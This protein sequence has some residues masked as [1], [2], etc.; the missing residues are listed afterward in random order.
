MRKN[1]VVIGLA[2]PV[3]DARGAR[4]RW[5][6]WRPTVSIGQ[7]QDLLVDRLELLVQ[8]KY[9]ALG[10][11]LAADFRQVSPETTVR[12]HQTVFAKPWDFESIY[13]E[14]LDFARHYPF[15]TEK[16]DYLVHITTGTHVMQICL[17]LLVESRII[18]AKILQ[19]G[20]RNKTDTVGS[21]SI[22]DLDLSRYDRLAERFSAVRREGLHF[23]KSGIETRSADYNRTIEQ[24]ARVCERSD[25]PIL[26]TGPS[27]VGKTRL[28]RLIYDW[29]KQNRRIS[30]AFVEL[31]CAT[32]RGTAAMSALFGHR[33]GAYTGATDS[34]RGLMAA[35]DGGLL[36]L[37]EV[38]ELGA[39]EQAMLLRAV[40]E[41]R[42]YPLGA[43]TECRS[44]FQLICGTNRDLAAMVREGRFRGDLFARINLWT[45]RLSGLRERP[46]DIEPNLDYELERSSEKLGR[47]VRMNREAKRAYLRAAASPDALWSGNFRD[48]AASAVRMSVLSESGRITESDVAEE[49]VRLRKGWEA[50]A[51]ASGKCPEENDEAVVRSVLGEG[52]DALDLFDVPQLAGVIRVCRRSKTASEAGRT[53]F[54]ESMK[55][56]KSTNDADRLR[57]YLAGFGLDWKR[58]TAER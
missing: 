49:L 18:P 47:L 9:R 36:F 27:G 54:A 46:E 29:K 45:F 41:K 20:L 16:E 2:G 39:D 56:R 28:A 19:T 25:D 55:R 53:L 50:E 35:A 26:L 38:G 58:V 15:D 23:L 3:L 12:L 13:E 24:I 44:D 4:D 48:L 10:D 6:K 34:R 17:F 30:G 32:L 8:D 33:K 57:K 43:D 40:E 52:F 37:D 14:L 1:T 5:Q 42:F 21:Y 7:H 22:I 11:E 31:N 51:P